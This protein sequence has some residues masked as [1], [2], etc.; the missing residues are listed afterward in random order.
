MPPTITRRRFLQAAGLATAAGAFAPRTLDS[1]GAIGRPDR[2]NIVVVVID[3]LRVDHVYGARAL[4]PNMDALVREG[5]RFTRAFP[6]AMPTVP[7][8]KSILTG[9]RQFPFRH[10]H[11]YEG[12]MA[13]PGWTP[14]RDGETSFTTVLRRAGYWTAYATDNPFLGWAR[15]YE[16]FR[17][18]FDR[19]V[20][21]GGQV[22]V[23][24]SPYRVSNRELMHWLHPVIRSDPKVRERVLRYMGNGGYWHDESRS[25]AAR[26]FRDGTRLLDAAARNRPFALVVDTFEP[27]EP[28]TPPREYLDLYGDPDYHG[29]EP[30]KPYYA[31]VSRYIDQSAADAV[32]AR[33]RALYAA[34]VTMTDR[35]LGVFIDRLYELGLDRDTA[36]VLVADHGIL[37]GDHGWTGKISIAL[38]TE[39]AQV[40]FVIVHPERRLAG[41][42]EAY[43]ASTHDLA[44][45]L[46]AMA[47]VRA[48]Q[49][50]DGVD[51][52]SLFEG[53]RPPE[54]P[55]AYGGY[56][57]AHYLRSDRWA[58]IASNRADNVKLFDL[59]H[60]PGERENLAAGRPHMAR[61]LHG[62]VVERAGGKLPYYADGAE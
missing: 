51:L 55:F 47:G 2:P 60:D 3:T 59:R 35:W 25:F 17:R 36:I 54:R 46:L 6:E 43:F 29:P 21:R 11:D 44:P 31:P 56:S 49:S 24:G 8:R 45:T 30:S 14:I 28:W 40:P 12:L 23:G 19:F 39:L 5:L 13:M 9:R 1:S 26:V 42:S 20:R 61:K 34:E 37:L 53:R 10:W 4:T 38:H 22:G 7:A 62:Q 33:M 16:P 27:H 48:P 32:L 57:N 58:L 18:G 52:S 15:T 41:Q 50:M